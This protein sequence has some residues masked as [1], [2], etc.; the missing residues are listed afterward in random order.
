MKTLQEYVADLTLA[1]ADSDNPENLVALHNKILPF[2]QDIR[3]QALDEAANLCLRDSTV[4]GQIFYPF[5]V[6]AAKIRH[7]DQ[8]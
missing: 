6:M 1:V 7:L 4:T 2:V 3:Q 5:R 8:I